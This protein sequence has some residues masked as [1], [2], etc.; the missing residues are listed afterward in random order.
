ML[1]CPTNKQPRVRKPNITQVY[2]DAIREMC[3]RCVGVLD[4]TSMAEV[5]DCKTD[6]DDPCPLWYVRP[7]RK[8][9]CPGRTPA[10][11]GKG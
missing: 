1:T 8:G 4:S 10:C 6:P 11:Q 2:K 5:F 3:R 9:D 7:K